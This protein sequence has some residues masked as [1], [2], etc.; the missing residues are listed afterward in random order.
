MSCWILILSGLAQAYDEDFLYFAGQPHHFPE[1]VICVLAYTRA[2]SLSRVLNSARNSEYHGAVVELRIWI[3][4]SPPSPERDEVIKV[5][6]EYDWPYGRKIVRGVE[7]PSIGLVGQWVEMC[8]IFDEG[9]SAIAGAVTEAQFE[10][11][12][13][14]LLP[15]LL[16]LHDDVTLS[17]LH[18]SWAQAAKKRYWRR[19]DI[20]GMT[21]ESDRIVS[22]GSKAGQYFGSVFGLAGEPIGSSFFYRM[23]GTHGFMTK[24]VVW[25]RFRS[26]YQKWDMQKHLPLYTKTVI[27]TY[28]VKQS[29]AGR[30]PFRNMPE[31]W[32]TQFTE[33][34]GGMWT[35]YANPVKCQNWTAAEQCCLLL[36]HREDGLHFDRSKEEV[37]SLY[38]CQLLQEPTED[39]FDI[40]KHPYMLDFDLQPI[41]FAPADNPEDNES[42]R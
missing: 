33:E 39:F 20:F 18:F 3:D 13:A 28:A 2:S 11:V 29:E 15:M 7:K 31:I 22:D 21:L 19:P 40:R 12:S 24:P 1:E 9:P 8:G 10:E 6:L 42:P 30:Q 16:I 41:I 25:R 17:P 38:D 23:C 5:A 34:M 35:V 32:T 26:W 4:W 14:G 27:T 37:K 36:H